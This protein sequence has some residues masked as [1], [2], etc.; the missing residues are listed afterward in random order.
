VVALNQAI[1]KLDFQEAAALMQWMESSS[2][3]DSE[4]P[5]EHTHA[6]F[7]SR[8][9]PGPSLDA[10]RRL[11]RRLT[12]SSRLPSARVC[13]ALI[14]CLGRAGEVVEAREMLQRMLYEE[15]SDVDV[16]AF[17]AA[18]GAAA[19]AGAWQEAQ[20]VWS[21]LCASSIAPDALSLSLLLLA[22]DKGASWS[23]GLAVALSEPGR[24]IHLDGPLAGSILGVA[25]KA[26]RPDVVKAIWAQVAQLRLPLSTHL[27]NAYL[28][29]L[30]ANGDSAEARRVL[31][32]MRAG[33]IPRDVRSYTAAMAATRLERETDARTRLR[34]MRALLAEML[35]EDI[36]PSSVTLNVFVTAYGDAAL[37][38]EAEAVAE[39]WRERYQL[40][41]LDERVWNGLIRACS[42][43]EQPREALRFF[44]AMQA[45][46]CL[47]SRA[48]FVLLSALSG[49][50]EVAASE[51]RK[52]RASLEEL[53]LP[54]LKDAAAE[55]RAAVEEPLPAEESFAPGSWAAWALDD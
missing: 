30:A 3:S 28:A 19:A 32:A 4:R 38:Q 14:S 16:R 40:G 17:N 50:V 18:L 8:C 9:G 15:L 13:T 46:G 11:W 48:T 54:Q 10:A 25:G 33:G 24:R 44:Q 43:A 29:A 12:V 31:G 26:G 1:L 23:E 27:C 51:L 6:A 52:L 20:V 53:E 37:W 36:A 7:L 5:N 21:E 49:D 35:A 41:P 47:P 42:R 34:K 39:E 55:A 22:A 2:A 45:A